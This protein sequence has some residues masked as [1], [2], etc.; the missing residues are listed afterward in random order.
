MRRTFLQTAF[1]DIAFN[2]A[3]LLGALF[4]ISFL[5]IG[6]KDEKGQVE[7]KDS[8][9]ITM[10]WNPELNYDI[11]MHVLSPEDSVLGFRVKDKPW[12]TLERDDL[13][14]KSDTLVINGIEKTFSYNRE[15]IHLRNLIEGT[16]YVNIHMYNMR[17]DVPPDSEQNITI[18]FLQLEPSYK[19]AYTKKY[20]L[21]LS[22]KE[23]FTSFS[24]EYEEGEDAKIFDDDQLPFVNEYLRPKE[25]NAK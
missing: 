23:E 19:I 25:N 14:V 20:D 17:R 7:V 13:G 8:F 22:N 12:G 18:E 24:F 15:V 4:I 6:N 11:D 3:L 10:T 16:Y 1:I 21:N 2:I 9:L 5:I